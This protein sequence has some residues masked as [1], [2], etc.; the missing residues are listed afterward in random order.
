MSPE[1]TRTSEKMESVKHA[2]VHAP[3]G[4]KRDAALKHYRAAEKAH[5]AKNDPETN[6]ELDAA[7]RA[8]A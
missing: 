3:A 5:T 7:T 8:L 1:Q 6:R 2:C 4:P